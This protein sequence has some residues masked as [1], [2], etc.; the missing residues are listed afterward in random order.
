MIANNNH[1]SF[2]Y[3]KGDYRLMS[4]I[5]KSANIALKETLLDELIIQA[6][7][8]KLNTIEGFWKKDIL[9]HKENDYQDIVILKA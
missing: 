4:T 8:E 7:L 6:E 9:N 1:F 5:V 3:N 2:P